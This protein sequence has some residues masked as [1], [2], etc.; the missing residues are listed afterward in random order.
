MF[1]EVRDKVASKSSDGFLRFDISGPPA[2]RTMLPDGVSSNPAVNV[3]AAKSETATGL[4]S[5]L[6]AG[7][8]LGFFSESF[9]RFGVET[10]LFS[11]FAGDFFDSSA[12]LRFRFTP[13][14]LETWSFVFC[15]DLALCSLVA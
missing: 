10:S 7:G 4:A 5:K 6:R 1:P 9:L 3:S 2:L 11:L 12:P 8:V 14:M 15:F 13:A